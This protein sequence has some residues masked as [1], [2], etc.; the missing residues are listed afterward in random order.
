MSDLLV[1]VDPGP[2]ARFEAVKLDPLTPSEVFRRVCEGETL[3][4]V[5]KAWGLPKGAFTEWYTTEFSQMYD[6]ALK[7]R[8]DELA[9]EAIAISDEQCAVEK[10]G[11][12]TYDP[13][14][15]RDKLRVDTRMKLAA[16]WDRKR[17]GEEQDAVR[18]APVIIQI[19]NLRGATL[20]V[21]QGDDAPALEVAP[22]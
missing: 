17:Y 10:E 21:K 1:S 8:A 9:H 4:E 15:P 13:E 7:V 20:E 16:K 5:A 3:R 22:I 19:A 11:G 2:I 12:G 6:A 18:T 14:V